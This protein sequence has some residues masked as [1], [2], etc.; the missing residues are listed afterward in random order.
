[1]F[2]IMGAEKVPKP[3]VMSRLRPMSDFLGGTPILI[4]P[5]ACLSLGFIAFVSSLGFIALRS[6]EPSSCFLPK[7]LT[8]RHPSVI[9]LAQTPVQEVFWP[10]AFLGTR[11][12]LL[13]LHLRRL[14]P[15]G[16]F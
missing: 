5:A 3:V 7:K 4:F 11:L 14:L 8:W 16:T 12:E 2:L 9:V 10:F 13:A 1:M 15:L 6:V